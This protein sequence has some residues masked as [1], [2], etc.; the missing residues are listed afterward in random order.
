[1]LWRIL[2]AN[3]GLPVDTLVCFANSGK[4]VEAPLRFVRECAE[5][6][7]GPVHWLDTALRSHSSAPAMMATSSR[8]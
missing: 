3:S 6:W 1:M 7:Q 5:R 2:Q 4:E 8:R